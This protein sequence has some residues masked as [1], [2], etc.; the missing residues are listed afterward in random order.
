MT[1]NAMKD[2]REKC[3]NVGA[4]DYMP[5]PVDTEKLISLLKV[6]LYAETEKK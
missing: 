3:L 1:A 4:N 5:K 2:D 6:W